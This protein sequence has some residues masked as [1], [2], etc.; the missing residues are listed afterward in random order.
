MLG[1]FRSVPT[2]VLGLL[3]SPGLTSAVYCQV[4]SS[5]NGP[6]PPNAIHPAAVKT[7]ICE[8]LAHPQTFDLKLAE[9]HA[10]FS[11][12]WE[13]AW[14]SDEGCKDAGEWVLPSQHGMPPPYA[15]PLRNVSKR[16]G[17][18]DVTRDKAWEDFESASSRLYTGMGE[19]LP[20]G[21]TK[22]GDYDYITAD[23][24]GVLVIKRNF[25]V[26]NGFGNGWGH[27]GMSR[28]LIV[29][30]SV[31]NVLPHQCTCPSSETLPSVLQLPSQP[32]PQVLLPSQSPRYS[33]LVGERSRLHQRWR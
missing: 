12:S 27:L 17:L 14:L 4:S 13:G 1:Q 10:K 16:Y 33:P 18:D 25:R 24:A 32:L 3:I 29:L 9:I 31:S 28:F 7:S 26:R 6:R 30:R 23:F 2:F 19:D 11:A 20:D 21:T 15:D 22:W 8:A 5:A